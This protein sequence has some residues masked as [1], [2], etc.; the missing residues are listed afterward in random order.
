MVMTY[1]LISEHQLTKAQSFMVPELQKAY[2]DEI[3]A[4]LSS[5][6]DIWTSI[7]S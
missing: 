7:C 1:P 4:R 5:I 6:V 2:L 3:K